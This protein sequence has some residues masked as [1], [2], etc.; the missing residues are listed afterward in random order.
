VSAFY[1][2]DID[3]D[4]IL[5]FTISVKDN[6]KDEHYLMLLIERNG[7]FYN[8]YFILHMKNSENAIL[9]HKLVSIT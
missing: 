9:H 3:A 8:A 6:L 7:L 5:D 2:F 1:D 4:L